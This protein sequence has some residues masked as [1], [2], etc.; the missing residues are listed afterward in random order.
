[1]QVACARWTRLRFAVDATAYPR[2]DACLLPRPGA[3]AQRRLPLRG[4][5]DHAR[6]GVPVH[7]G[8]GHLRTA[9]AALSTWRAPRPRPGPHDIAQVK[10]VL[11]RLCAAGHGGK[12]R[13]CSS[14]TPATAP[15][16]STDGLLGCPVH[17]LVRLPRHVF[18]ADPRHLGG[19]ARP[20]SPARRCGALPGACDSPLPQQGSGPRGRKKPLPRTRNPTRNSSPP[21]P[22]STAPSGPKGLARRAPPDPRRPRLRSPAGI[23]N[24]PVLPGT[25]HP[26]HRR[27]PARRAGPRVK[28]LWL[29]HAGPHS[30][31]WISLWPAYLARFDHRARLQAPQGHPRASPPRRLKSPRAGRPLAT[32]PHGR[33][34]PA[35]AQPAPSPRTYAGPGR[36]SLD[37]ARPLAPARV[38]RGFRRQ[39]PPW[40]SGTP[41][42][43]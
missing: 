37:P 15:P 23:G 27:A 19:Q 33:T 20:P 32:A 36:N 6:L 24:L 16:R 21:V 40:T 41:A 35:P 25:L 1:M 34:R 39:H 18:Y 26:R 2:P 42:P 28:V 30:C 10:G 4:V 3:C 12:R 38:R 11:G 29:W 8:A 13:R 5:Q 9:W 22:R 31:P 17:V 7:R 14:S 43:V